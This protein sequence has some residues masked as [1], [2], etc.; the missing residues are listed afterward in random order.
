MSKVPTNP[1]LWD[2][3]VFQAKARFKTYPSPS[4]SHW[5]HEEYTKK[6]GGFADSTIETKRR[7]M[8]AAAIMRKRRE[9]ASAKS[10]KKK[11]DKK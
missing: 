7:E 4:A 8:M 10:D 3:I 9:K 2:L 1:K 5:V 11:G 6:G